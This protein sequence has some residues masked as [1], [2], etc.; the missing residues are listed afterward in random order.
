MSCEDRILENYD[1]GNHFLKTM[2]L[3]HFVDNDHDLEFLNY[4]NW[5]LPEFLPHF[6]G[7][8]DEFFKQSI[9]WKRVT[10]NVL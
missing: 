1:A 4:T 7:V 9:C 3:K 10:K 8:S 2:F 6:S 5:G